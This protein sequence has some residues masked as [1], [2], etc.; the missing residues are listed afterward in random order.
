MI[1]VLTSSAVDCEFQPKSV[2]TKDNKIG[3]F[4]FSAKHTALRRKSKDSMVRNQIMCLNRAAS[5]PTNSCFSEL[6]L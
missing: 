1:S 5:L 2:Q 4:C 3:I 6:S